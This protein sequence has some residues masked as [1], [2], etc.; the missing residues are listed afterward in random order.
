[1]A[2][3]LSSLIKSSD[4]VPHFFNSLVGGSTTPIP[5]QDAPMIKPL[6]SDFVRF[7]SFGDPELKNAKKIKFSR[8]FAIASVNTKVLV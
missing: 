7:K 5:T 1:M 8:K 3:D 4:L 2:L 6:F